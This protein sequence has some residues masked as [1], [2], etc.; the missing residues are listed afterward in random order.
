MKIELD[1]L[2]CYIFLIFEYKD[3][4]NKKKNLLV[5]KSNLKKLS[6]KK[7]SK[8]QVQK[9]N[10]GS[11][12]KKRRIKKILYSRLYTLRIFKVDFYKE[13]KSNLFINTISNN[14]Y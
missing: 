10:I 4:T 12:Y 13:K 11:N 3:K 2:I 14:I 5:K 6:K 7:Q 9:I 8:S 1:K